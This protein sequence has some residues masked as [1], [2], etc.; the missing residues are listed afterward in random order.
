MLFPV[1]RKLPW[2][3]VLLA[4]GC[5]A[6]PTNPAPSPS[7]E[8]AAAPVASLTIRSDATPVLGIG[9]FTPFTF[10]ASASTGADL[11]YFLEFGDGKT[12]TERVAT[13]TTDLPADRDGH[14]RTA[15]LTVSDRLGRS[16]SVTQDYFVASVP[17]VDF[18]YSPSP[19]GRFHHRLFLRQEGDR[20]TGTYSGP[21][22]AAPGSSWQ[23]TGRLTGTR[24]IELQTENG[25]IVLTGSLEWAA[26]DVN[27]SQVRVVLRMAVRGG[28]SDGRTIDFRWADI[29]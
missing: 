10:D 14:K 18:W 4:A 27:M 17:T 3:T 15:R 23:L 28:D 2:C 24:G 12:S 22:N 11:I 6:S 7:T 9:G 26:G 8:V 16:S 21:E 29:Y 19:G 13:H 20:I 5:A 1:L 25:R